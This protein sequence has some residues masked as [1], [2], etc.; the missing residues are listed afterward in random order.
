[1]RVHVVSDVHGASD[2][3][4]RAGDG[5]DALVVLGDL[6]DYVDYRD[7]A[8]GILGRVLGPE[9]S[10]E[11]A[12]LRT[13][14]GRDALIRFVRD[15]WARVPDAP[16]VVEDAV[17]EQYDRLF[18]ALTAPTYAIPGNVDMPRLWPRYAGPGLT[19]ADGRVVEIG[20]LR[21][22]FVGGAPLPPGV[23]PG[24]GGPWTPHL[25]R[26]TEFTAAVKALDRVDVLCSH[27]PP[28]VPEL[29]FDVVTRRA[30]ASSVALLDV[31]HRDRPRAALFG[32]VHQPLAQR[33]RVG[34]T[35]CV[36][37]GHFRSTGTPYVLRW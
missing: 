8:G 32:H 14:G 36:N 5:A 7:P 16:A 31:V 13:A 30:E 1:M 9:V 26:A 37:V 22:G 4:A 33:V 19:L 12:R 24:T 25:L 17:Q 10:A 21:F 20:D 35:E 18:G 34:R 2:T 29:A 15:A 28:A 3:L 27:V 6:V 11:F 23:E